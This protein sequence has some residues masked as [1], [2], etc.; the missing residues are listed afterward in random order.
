[1]RIAFFFVLFFEL[2]RIVI[3]SVVFLG[4]VKL[5][6]SKGSWRKQGLDLFKYYRY[7]PHGVDVKICGIVLSAN[8]CLFSVLKKIRH[9]K[10]RCERV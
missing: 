7:L 8:L 10:S 6:F 5:L 1:M 3:D 2:K 9:R 4:N